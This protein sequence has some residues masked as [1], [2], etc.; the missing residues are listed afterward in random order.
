VKKEVNMHQKPQDEN[1]S[2]IQANVRTEDQQLELLRTLVKKGVLELK[3]SFDKDGVHYVD[4]E[5]ILKSA[6]SDVVKSVLEDLTMKGLLKSRIVSRVLTCPRCGSPDIHSKFTCPRCGFDSVELTELIEHPKCGYIGVRVDFLRNSQLVCPRCGTELSDEPA[7]YRIIGNFYQC[8]NCGNRFDK[9]EVLHICQNC[10]KSSTFQDVKYVKVFSFRISEE[11]IKQL[12]KE[13]PIFENVK[14]LLLDKGFRVR[15][16]SKVAGSSG[17]QSSFDVYAEMGDVRLV[18]DASLEG[19]RNDIVGLLAK[20]V[21]VNPTRA[22]IF[23][24][25]DG[26]ELTL[27]GKVYDITVFKVGINQS[28]PDGFEGFLESLIQKNN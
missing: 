22:V 28:V 10:G 15:L 2:I 24:L 23:D 11:T 27:L 4:A 12:G 18:F 5:E 26:D 8:D 3:P 19:S 21:D 14:E 7:N 1:V 13:L 9:P 16:H 6:D 17:V 25:S 20:K